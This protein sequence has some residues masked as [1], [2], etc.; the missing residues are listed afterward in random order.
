MF[1]LGFLFFVRKDW[2]RARAGL[3]IYSPGTLNSLNMTDVRNISGAEVDGI[4][5]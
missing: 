2:L 3:G 5:L 1:F 4:H